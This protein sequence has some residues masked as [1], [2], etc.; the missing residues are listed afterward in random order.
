MWDTFASTTSGA[1]LQTAAQCRLLLHLPTTLLPSVSTEAASSRRYNHAC[2]P[3]RPLPHRRQWPGHHL[4][5]RPRPAPE[6]TDEVWLRPD[7]TASA[8]PTRQSSPGR[9]LWTLN[10]TTA[11]MYYR[12]YVS[13]LKYAPQGLHHCWC[14]LTPPGHRTSDSQRQASAKGS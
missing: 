9:V 14:T 5:R 8:T 6:I 7:F 10:A 13:T 11:V 1:P 2:H 4:I 12:P 3:Y